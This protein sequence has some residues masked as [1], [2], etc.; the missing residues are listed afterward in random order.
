M[1]KWFALGE[2]GSASCGVEV[3]VVQVS[4][5]SGA[6]SL[7]LCATLV[8]SS[9]CDGAAGDSTSRKLLAESLL[10]CDMICC[11]VVTQLFDNN[12]QFF[13]LYRLELIIQHSTSSVLSCGIIIIIILIKCHRAQ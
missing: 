3:A 6:A 11:A 8:S 13:L 5:C 7:G 9:V 2:A 12:G 1:S 4:N 10:V